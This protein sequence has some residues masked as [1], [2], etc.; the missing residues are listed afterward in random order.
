MTQSLREQATEAELVNRMFPDELRKLDSA[1]DLIFCQ[2]QSGFLQR[3]LNSLGRGAA[4]Y[5]FRF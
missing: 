3:F 4:D 2:K 5:V 1:A